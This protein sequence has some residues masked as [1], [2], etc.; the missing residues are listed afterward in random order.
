MR[1]ASDEHRREHSERVLRYALQALPADEMSAM[2][3]HISGCADCRREM[4]ALRR[5]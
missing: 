5:V 2:E 1:P 3:A 4:Q